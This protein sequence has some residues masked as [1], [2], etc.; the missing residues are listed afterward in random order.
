MKR[1]ATERGFTL[2]EVLVASAIMGIAV[3]GLLASLST[4]MRTAGRLT[5]YD[6]ATLL[7]RQKMDELLVDVKAPRS[8]PFHGTWDP[9][10]TSGLP[11]GWQATIRP[12][13]VPQGAGPGSPVLDRIELTIWWMANGQRRTFKFEGYRQGIL[14]AQDLAGGPIPPPPQ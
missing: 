6:R 13:D 12:W 7:A 10:L 3:T 11:C 2:L 9:A 4:S 5:D 1:P 14:T 8:V